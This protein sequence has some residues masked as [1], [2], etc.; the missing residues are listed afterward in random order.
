M[1]SAL[2]VDIVE[3]ISIYLLLIYIST[4]VAPRALDMMLGDGDSRQS[5]LCNLFGELFASLLFSSS[6]TLL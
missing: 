3:T 4:D 2:C 1:D 6:L 5:E